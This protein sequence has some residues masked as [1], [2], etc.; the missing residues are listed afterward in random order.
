MGGKL[1][2]P[3]NI[4][5]NTTTQIKTIKGILKRIVVNAL[6][7]GATITV[8]N[9]ASADS[10]AIATIVPTVTGTLEFNC[11]MSIGI[12]VKTAGSAACNITVVT[13]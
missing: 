12:R 2:S 5:T 9:H 10:N 4:S 8:Y 6:G 13:E 7:T 3:T 11:W 1:G